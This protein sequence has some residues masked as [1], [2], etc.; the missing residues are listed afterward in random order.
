MSEFLGDARRH[1]EKIEHYYA[2]AGAFGY[3]QAAHHQAQLH[4]LLGRAA[5]SKRGQNDVIAI[6]EIL[7]D[8]CP[9]MEEMLKREKGAPG[10]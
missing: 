6:Q 4:D 7:K 2:H 9:K 3:A 1:A 10:S 8:V 5:K